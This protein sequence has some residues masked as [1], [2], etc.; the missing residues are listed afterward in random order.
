MSDSA[1]SHLSPPSR[2]NAPHSPAR[3]WGAL[4]RA[5]ALIRRVIG[6]PDY[7]LYLR[8][9]SERHP[10]VPPLSEDEFLAERL[11]AKYSRPGQRCC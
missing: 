11:E 1:A 2:A 5:A 4:A 8:H 10:E 9:A 6:A 3:T 7:A